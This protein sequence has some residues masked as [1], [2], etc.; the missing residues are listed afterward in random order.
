LPWRGCGRW[1]PPYAFDA[2]VYHL[3]QVTL[4]LTERSIFVPVDSAYAGFPG[5]WQM[6]YAFTLGLGGESASQLLHLT[7][8]PLTVLV[9]AAAGRRLWR[10]D[11]TWAVA[12]L[13]TAVRPWCLSQHGR[14]WTWP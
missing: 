6:L 1:A 4:Y 3:R 7:C 9:A 8:L 2:L 14:T 13:L 12:G 5:L 11:L 10:I